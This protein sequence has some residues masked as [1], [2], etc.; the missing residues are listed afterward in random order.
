[1]LRAAHI[2][3]APVLARILGDWFAATPYLPRLRT[4]EEDR[5][6]VETLIKDADVLVADDDRPV[7]FIAR[8]GQT[9][10]QL[11]VDAAARGKGIGSQLLEEMKSRTDF[12]NLWCFDQNQDAKRFYERHGFIATEFT[13]EH[14]NEE[15]VPDVRYAWRRG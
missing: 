8:E 14:R 7:G 3:D 9:I 10:S 11:Y 1:M 12:L 4:P 13:D 6:F 2:D 15:R 5:E